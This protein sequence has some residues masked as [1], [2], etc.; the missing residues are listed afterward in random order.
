MQDPITTFDAVRDFYITYLETAFRIGDA[1]TQ[2][3]RRDLLEK[4]GALAT[5][6]LLE[7]LPGYL[8]HGI[9]I[10]SLVDEEVGA[11]WLP[12]FSQ[13][14]R[15]AFSEICLAGLIPAAPENPKTGRFKLYR[16]QLEM[17]R[18]GVC[19]GTPGI[20]TSGTGSGKTES[21]LLP[22]LAAIVK[23]G[24]CWARSKDLQNWQAWWET[25][26]GEPTF[27]REP[28]NE[29]AQRPKAV[30][31]IVLYPM[32]ALVEDQM[33]RLRKALD[34]TA[35]H[36]AMDK[37]LG[38]N[39]IFFGR[40][41]GATKVTG[42]LKHPRVNDQQERKKEQRRIDELRTYLQGLDATQLAAR[43]E[44]TKKGD[45]SLPFN[46]PNAQG[47]EVVSRWD[48]QR[49]P[50]DIL[51]T[52]TSMLS[53]MLVREIDEPIFD[54]TRT[55]IE[56]SPDSY[57]YLVLDEL[58][59]Q[60]G[61]AGTEIAYL[62]RSMIDRLGLTNPAHRHKLRVLCS[63]AS[64]PN[65]G[66]ELDQTL[67]YLWG[68]F[69]Q[70]G[71]PETGTRA[72]WARAIVKGDQRPVEIVK[73]RGD[74]TKLIAATHRL[75][76]QLEQAA[77][78][79]D[80]I[81]AWADVAAALG[82]SNL[83]ARQRQLMAESV[84]EW[85][86]RL[87][88]MGCAHGGITRA[89]A[90]SKIG[91]RVF[92]EDP[93]AEATRSLVW[94][95]SCSDAW[96]SW[97]DGDFANAT[98]PRF[99][100]H[101]FIRAIEGLFAAPRAS[102][103]GVSETERLQHLFGD[104]SIE[105]GERYGANVGGI[106]PRRTDMLYCE[107]CGTLFLGGKRGQ[108]SGGRVELLPNDPDS[109]ALPERAKVN[110]VE[111]NSAKDYC[112]F[113][114]TVSRFK[115][116][117]TED[118]Q[119]DEAQGAWE[120]AEYDPNTATIARVLPGAEW[121]PKM[122]PG[123][124]YQVSPD[125][126]RFRRESR[127]KQTCWSDPSSALPFQCPACGISYRK[128]RGRPSPVRGFRVGFA[129]T[130]QLL[131]SA[132]MSELRRSSPNE[133]LVSFSDSRQDAAKAAFDL[134]SGHHDDVRREAVVRSLEAIGRSFEDTNHAKEEYDR[135]LRRQR[136]IFLKNDPTPEELL[137]SKAIG[138]R[139]P[140]LEAMARGGHD[141]VPL[142]QILEPA[143]P[144]MGAPLKP[145]LAKLVD[146]GI[147]PI[148]PTGV[149]PVPEEVSPGGISFAWQQLFEKRAA[150]W[151]WV[152]S[153]TRVADFEHA[154]QTISDELLRLVGSSLFS[155]T[156]FAVEESGWGYP[157]LPLY[158]GKT[159]ND[160]A[161]FDAMIRVLADSFRL[162]PTPFTDNLLFW[163]DARDALG[164]RRLRLFLEGVRKVNG[165]S[166][167]AIA[168]Q[169][170]AEMRRA[171]H[172]QGIISVRELHYRALG[173]DA[174]YWRCQCGRVHMHL[175]A[176]VCTRCYR[177][178]PTKSTGTAG[179]LRSHSFL[180]KRIIDSQAIHRMR[181]E[182]LTGMTNNPAARLRR[183]KNILIED[184][185][186]I[187][188]RGYDGAASERDLDEKARVV[189]VLSVTTTMEVGVDIGELRSVFQANMPPQRFNYQQRVGRAG[190]RGQAF[191]LALTVCRS[192]SHDLHYFRYP[193]Q[194][195]GDPPP[196]P[197]LTSSLD[198]IVQR[199]VLKVWLVAAFRLL[200]EQ[201]GQRWAGDELS[202]TP[203][204][205]GEFLLVS[206]V[207]ADRALWLP[208]IREALVGC[209]GE[210][211]RF[212]G[213]CIAGQPDR[214]RNLLAALT[215]D[216]VIFRLTAVIEDPLMQ[217]KGL[218][219]A[220]A[221]LGHF[222]MYGMPTR[223]RLLYTRPAVQ[224]GRMN[225]LS[226][227]RDLDV[228]VQEFAPGKVLVQD[229]RR[230]FTTGYAGDRLQED[231]GVQAGPRFISIPPS[232]GEYRRLIECATC[233][234]W[235][236]SDA[237]GDERCRACGAELSG[238]DRRLIVT[239]RGF[240]TTLVSRQPEDVGEE[241]PTKASKSSIA[242]TEALS[243]EHIFGSNLMMSVS[244]QSQLFRLNRGEFRDGN[245]T[246]FTAEQGNLEATYRRS[247]LRQTIT[248]R[249]VWVDPDAAQL[250]TGSDEIKHRFKFTGQKTEPFYLGAP[251]VT[252]S[253]VL[254][255]AHV[256]PE[257]AVVRNAT[258]GERMLTPAFRAGA[259]SALFMIVTQASRNLLDVDPSEF[260]ILE[261]RVHADSSGTVFP[262]LQVSDELVNGSGLTDRLGQKSGAKRL[263]VV[264]N[265]IREI[266]ANP[267]SSPLTV[268]LEHDH[269]ANCFTGCYRCLHR[270]GNQAYHGLLDWR[271]GLDV[272]SLLDNASYTAGL[273]GD[274][275]AP[276]VSSWGAMA[277]ALAHDAAALCSPGSDV[278][279]I[280]GLYVFTLSPGRRAAVVH[281]L[282]AKESLLAKT[283]ELEELQVTE[284][285]AL[286]STFE[287]ARRMGATLAAL[288]GA[289]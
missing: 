252:D 61:S 29:S 184:D 273:D 187:L 287:L 205:H 261:P 225:L 288:R 181:A 166:P 3:R 40:Y 160:L 179:E 250:D 163:T 28:P 94:L 67:D 72:D 90:L 8:D 274:F 251:K 153:Q 93:N 121:S 227:D 286:V 182:E 137:E 74:R 84:I 88:E 242:V 141:C 45:E 260:E 147:H 51:I 245:W 126:K 164:S 282:W 20:V 122:V 120:E 176:R 276:G 142:Q 285:L 128:T 168:E 271:L 143:R 39:R 180:G 278:E 190:R 254:L 129:K 37:H 230:Y 98:T 24:T 238:S 125:P 85:A 116:F 196:P 82:L 146:A 77:P 257:L 2:N 156:Y 7:P 220:L 175:G 80:E 134:E 43:A 101:T 237:A 208:R 57:F 42:W 138:D 17:L 241:L 63:S 86:G 55:W 22:I 268:M 107:C 188:P 65:T 169:L 198:T 231:R 115:P 283:P 155:K 144:R 124:L 200:R 229:K 150:E 135:L 272:L 199:L 11:K 136:T 222:P 5:E 14:E 31:A 64:L 9:T 21:F 30:R 177:P 191:S 87:L 127:R 89:T 133:R 267:S 201:A 117:G 243:F 171:G 280:A 71:L 170:L 53:T 62:I 78:P 185:D 44:A 79:I 112:I 83:G 109:E 216:A 100:V 224:N 165:E 139:L 99:R 103:T 34:S 217:G 119:W 212:A 152:R 73:F 91:T 162:Q 102:P 233:Q 47:N 46:F 111:Q 60:R 114:P 49:H 76:N 118:L 218:A 10:D 256:P 92:G 215:A 270:Y 58:H 23:E 235:A 194:I 25:A 36:A 110:Q 223:I 15:E 130:T 35:A 68:F 132:L 183:F 281:P 174:P 167:S 16:H 239:P 249:D 4:V 50:P 264:L 66:S 145:V 19:N 189:D 210:R 97:F 263:P 275:S 197:F 33:V 228:A 209:I 54:K 232:I 81:H 246:G 56:Q 106:R 159:R 244:K 192:K 26:S 148:D 151:C 211:D 203:D 157:C 13:N 41:T 204:N 123:W 226:M 248:V 269:S 219:E 279:S 95:R 221:E 172:A 266:L 140:E 154:F 247:G 259:L 214:L 173:S 104:L 178:L 207:L 38:G 158:A 27:R 262:L 149:T 206:S 265:V 48:M 277:R 18:K 70:A 193:E 213:L 108:A 96:R 161:P 52:N 240:I 12:G 1:A 284:G 234:A 195:T 186:D 6:P 253:L 202:S 32:N 131:A 258:S 236:D 113:M 75:K 105:S 69:G 59:L 289:P 255:P